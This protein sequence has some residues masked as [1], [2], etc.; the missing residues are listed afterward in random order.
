MSWYEYVIFA[1][2]VLTVVGQVILLAIAVSYLPGMSIL[3]RAWE[4]DALWGMFVVSLV[5]M[6]GSLF[7]SEVAGIEPCVL[8]WYQRIAM[9]PLVAI[10][11]VGLWRR[12]PNVAYY[13]LPLCMIGGAIAAWHYGEH[14]WT[15]MHPHDPL[16]PCSLDGISCAKPPFW[17]LG[18][19]TIP[20]MAF[21]AFALN[22]VGCAWLLKKRP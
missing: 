18:Y 2:S 8:C 21:T 11:A 1:C 5:A 13:A 20:L 4:R 12:D 9:Y 15:A 16:V 14:V 22:A 7:F 17:H 19:V 6:A 10:T 3:R